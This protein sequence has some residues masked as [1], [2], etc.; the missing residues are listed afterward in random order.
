VTFGERVRSLVPVKVERPDA[1]V[2]AL[3]SELTQAGGLPAGMKQLTLPGRGG[4]FLLSFNRTGTTVNRGTEQLLRAYASQPWLRG[5]ESKV[6]RGVASTPW[7]VFAV[8]GEPAT[9]PRRLRSLKQ[10]FLLS[11]PATRAG[12]V[13]GLAKQGVLEP[14]DTS[15][16]LDFLGRGNP[17]HPG[18]LTMQLTQ[19][20]LDLVGEAF[21]LIERDQRGQPLFYWNLPPSWVRSTPLPGDPVPTF[22]VRFDGPEVPIPAS[23][24]IWY[25]DPDPL[26]PYGR[27]TGLAKALGDEL[28]T[29]EFAA[30]YLRQWFLN[31]AIPPVIVSGDG[32]QPQ[33]TARLESDWTSRNQG[34][35]QR[36]KPYFMSRK[37]EVTKLAASFAEM[38]VVD[39]RKN[40]RDTVMQ[41][42]GVPPEVFG[43]LENSNRATIESADFL[44]A[45]WVLVPRLELLRATAQH[46]LVPMFGDNLLLDYVSPVAEDKE[47]TLKVMQ[48]A[49]WAFTADEWRALAGRDELPG[50]GAIHLVPFNLLG[51]KRLSDLIADPADE[52]EPEPEPEPTP[53]P[54][55]EDEPE[56]EPE[57]EEDDEK[58]RR[59]ALPA[60]D[61]KQDDLTGE[62][63][64]LVR[65]TLAAI[66]S[67]LLE[68]Q[69]EPV[70]AG[71]LEDFGN[72]AVRDALG[73]AADFDL[74]DPRVVD[75][76]KNRTSDKIRGATR[77][78]QRQVARALAA[79]FAE[80]ESIDRLS[81]RVRAVFRVASAVRAHTIARTETVRAANFGTLEGSRQAGATGKEW[82]AVRD[83][84][85]R[86]AHQSLDGTVVGIDEDFVSE[87][88]GSGPHPGE[89]DEASDDIQCRCTTTSVFGEASAS[90]R[91]ADV[92]AAIWAA[93]E[94]ERAPWE[95]LHLA[96]T[97]RGL[98]AQSAA[99]VSALRG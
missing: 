93:F 22:R 73:Q 35:W 99:A 65:R 85:T 71:T 95:R 12:L 49:S 48:A 18:L 9:D 2:L 50:D 19:T 94:Q 84:R 69:V 29:D 72:R 79:G 62:Q 88:G 33:E 63:A 89:M 82:V 92:R 24:I 3:L 6:A 70:A 43:I 41:V 55:D 4:T 86:D 96:A 8:K 28:D 10:R 66:K 83:E 15:P 25:Q 37:V 30:K 7:Q 26:Q 1:A 27:G 13:R 34:F 40:Q 58:S 87:N 90:A 5:I 74:S 46:R 17:Y 52:R 53:E 77:T 42:Y 36:F 56:D 91:T 78:T 75:Y 98:S 45:R 51:V 23:E 81:Q 68:E 47:F 67:R 80:G 31:D 21:W 11:G 59:L 64:E 76:L 16:L 14:L 61:R 39:L 60:P 57:D 44:M 54:D 38:Q 32:L 97:R 20:H